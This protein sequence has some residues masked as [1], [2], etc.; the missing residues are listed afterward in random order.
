MLSGAARAYGPFAEALLFAAARDDHLD[1]TIRPALSAGKWVLSDRFAD[2][3]RTYQGVAGKVDS[4]LIR[5]LERLIVGD[6]KPDLTIILDLP[7]AEGLKRIRA[8]GG[9]L[10]RYEGEGLVFH[11]RLRRAFLNIAQAEPERCVVIDANRP[12]DEVA[13]DVLRVVQERLDIAVKPGKDR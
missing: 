2:S 13:A 11:E 4:N 6:T 1:V 5:S 9:E 3:T 8:R 10:D 7:V 12:A